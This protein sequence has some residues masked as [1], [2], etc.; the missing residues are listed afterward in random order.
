MQASFVGVW[1]GALLHLRAHYLGKRLVALVISWR[2][3]SFVLLVFPDKNQQ[4]RIEN[5]VSLHQYPGI[6]IIVIIKSL[7]CILYHF[8]IRFGAPYFHW[9]N[10]ARKHEEMVERWLN[11]REMKST[12]NQS[13]LNLLNFY[14]LKF[15]WIV[16]W[17]IQNHVI[18]P[19]QR[20][21]AKRRPD[22]IFQAIWSTNKGAIKLDVVSTRYHPRKRSRS[23][24]WPALESRESLLQ[25]HHLMWK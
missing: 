8:I 17:S 15:D 23:D 16:W 7:H 19:L 5:Q 3:Q 6:A 12:N 18:Q 10:R 1:S 2:P 22:S 21:R 25:Y 13:G 9:K 4:I 14:F 20:R 11:I 24:H